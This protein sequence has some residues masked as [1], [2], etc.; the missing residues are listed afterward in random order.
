MSKK[1]PAGTEVRID[2]VYGSYRGILT[3]A[4]TD[5][6]DH[7]QLATI[8]TSDGRRFRTEGRVSRWVDNPAPWSREAMKR[9]NDSAEE[10]LSALFKRYEE[11]DDEAALEELDEYAY[12][13]DAKIVVT[14]TIAGGGPSQWITATYDERGILEQAEITAT[15][16]DGTHRHVAPDGSGVAKYAERYGD[17]VLQRVLEAGRR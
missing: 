9:M 1:I 16:G 13:D 5:N 4:V 2:N 3:S 11:D 15:Y 12:G 10:T 7:H 14:L 6:P 8:K 17:V